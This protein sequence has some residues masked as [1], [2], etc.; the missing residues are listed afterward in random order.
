[1]RCHVVLDPVALVDIDEHVVQQVDGRQNDFALV[2]LTDVLDGIIVEVAL[3]RTDLVIEHETVDEERTDLS[4]ED[5]RYVLR[6]LCCQIEEDTL[7]TALSC[8]ERQT[9]VEF[10][11]GILGLSIS[12]DLVDE[13]DERID[14]VFADD[15][16]ADKVDDHASDTFCCTE[17][18]S[19]DIEADV[20]CVQELVD[21]IEEI[22]HRRIVREE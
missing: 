20:R 4:E 11:L 6:V 10:L 2:E 1:M 14:V 8:E 13:E 17:L 9:A 12:V 5:R 15:E 19:I 16:R 7:L 18:G 3:Y 22:V 21:Y